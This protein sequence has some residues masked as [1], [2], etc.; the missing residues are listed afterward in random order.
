MSEP[1]LSEGKTANVG[2]LDIEGAARLLP[3]LA[4]RKAGALNLRLSPEDAMYDNND[5]HYLGVGE[6]ALNVIEAA[7]ALARAPSP[8]AILD[9]GAGAGRVTRWLRAAF[10]EAHISAC[11]VR[12]QDVQFCR[13]QFGVE[14]WV[15]GVNIEALAAPRTYDL[16]WVGSVLTHLSAENS[17]RLIDKLLSWTNRR[18]LLIMSIVGRTLKAGGGADYIH[19]EGWAEITRQ[20]SELGYG[21][22]D[23]LNMPGYGLSLTKLSWAAGVVESLPGIRLVSL[24]EGVWDNSHD[25]LAIQKLETASVGVQ[26][27]PNAAT[28][29]ND[30][31]DQR[32]ALARGAAIEFLHAL[33]RNASDPIR[34]AIIL[35]LIC[36]LSRSKTRSWRERFRPDCGR[37]S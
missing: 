10:P 15:S 16:I 26:S 14:G 29:V 37:L 36:L 12:P 20:Y 1:G 22:A 30:L 19:P 5:A 3:E 11:D 33:A 7:R 32:Q 23:Y 2:M 21:Y 34:C 17:A 27:A 25:I 8:G 24:S 13:D 18:G 35:A 28:V 9:F 31:L 4:K 6:S